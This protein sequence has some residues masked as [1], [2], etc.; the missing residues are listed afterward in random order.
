MVWPKKKNYNAHPLLYTSVLPSNSHPLQRTMFTAWAKWA[1]KLPFSIYLIQNALYDTA[2]RLLH[3]LERFLMPFSQ[4]L[5]FK[6]TLFLSCGTISLSQV[7]I[8]STSLN[9]T[10]RSQFDSSGSPVDEIEAPKIFVPRGSSDKILG[11][12]VGG[13]RYSC[14]S[15]HN[16]TQVKL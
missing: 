12:G 6:S 15:F 9:F 3:T 11:G 13:G 2:Y 8:S 10:E 14:G 4:S 16:C 7:P 1:V 5:N